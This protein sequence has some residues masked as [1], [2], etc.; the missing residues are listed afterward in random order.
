MSYKPNDSII[1]D[2]LGGE[3]SAEE[4]TKLEAYLAEHPEEK[5]ELE[6]SELIN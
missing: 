1:A 4:T 5:R 3:L 6:D 2:Y